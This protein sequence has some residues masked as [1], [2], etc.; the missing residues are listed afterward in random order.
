MLPANKKP[1]KKQVKAGVTTRFCASD[2]NDV[3]NQRIFHVE[4]L[5]THERGEEEN[6]R[7][8]QGAERQPLAR[9]SQVTLLRFLPSR[10]FISS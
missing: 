6:C 9:S 4:D 3:L 10:S 5:P 1:M 8:R 2:T 7:V